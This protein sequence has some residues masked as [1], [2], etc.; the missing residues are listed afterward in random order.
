MFEENESQLDELNAQFEELCSFRKKVELAGEVSLQTALESEILLGTTAILEA[1][2]T[3][4]EIGS[5][6]GSAI[7]EI[8]AGIYAAV[9]NIFMAI[10]N[11]IIKIIRWMR[12]KGF[13]TGSSESG[14]SAEFIAAPEQVAAVTEV[15]SDKEMQQA[16]AEVQKDVEHTTGNKFFKQDMSFNELNESS[17]ENTATEDFRNPNPT[18]IREVFNAFIEGLSEGEIDYLTSGKKTKIV[19]DAIGDFAT[20]NFGAF[21]SHIGNDLFKWTQDGLDASKHVGKDEGVVKEFLADQQRKFDAILSKYNRDITRIA[22][23]E[24]RYTTAQASGSP[25]HL[26]AYHNRP[27]ELFP[28]LEKTWKEMGFERIGHEELRLIKSLEEVQKHY[29]GNIK[30]LKDREGS[31]ERPWPP[32]EG[33]L[34]LANKAHRE[35]L[36]NIKSLTAIAHFVRNNSKIAHSAT[37]KSFNYIFKVLGV[38]NKLKDVDRAKIISC[39][40]I[41]RAKRDEL[42]E[43]L[44]RH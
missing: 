15:I 35:V 37:V 31:R 3:P 16:V 33:M 41:L 36:Q 13:N 30:N 24:K 26:Y 8:I 44:E 5:K 21:I 12:G 7:G 42:Q 43:A 38:I 9:I 27:S 20:A 18:T 40:E 4:G 19:K 28:H 23:M 39:V 2:F 6:T 11:I 34:R 1:H 10:L 22:D 14:G 32:E 17:K 29:E 25:N